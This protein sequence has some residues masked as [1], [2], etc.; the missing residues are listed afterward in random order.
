MC[1]GEGQAKQASRFHLRK[2]HL[3][4][5]SETE[6][7][8]SASMEQDQP[9]SEDDVLLS[10]ST[11]SVFTKR[12]KVGHWITDLKEQTKKQ[13]DVDRKKLPH[14][15]QKEQLSSSFPDFFPQNMSVTSDIDA[16]PKI[17]LDV[18]MKRLQFNGIGVD[19]SKGF[20][21]T[22]DE[23]IVNSWMQFFG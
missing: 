14:T 19:C 12:N 5:I 1:W 15:K 2:I 18:Y 6:E 21:R 22:K 23:K 9:I 20:C 11:E 4:T 8:E 10:F 16:S 17:D 13:A 3:P 7:S